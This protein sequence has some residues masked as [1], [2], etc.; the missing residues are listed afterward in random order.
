MKKKTIISIIVAIIVL[1]I[2]IE[3]ITTKGNNKEKNV[4]KDGYTLENLEEWEYEAITRT[5]KDIL[6]EDGRLLFYKRDEVD[7]LRAFK[8]YLEQK[9]PNMKFKIESIGIEGYI[10]DSEYI[11]HFYV[12]GYNDRLFTGRRWMKVGEEF[13]D[14]FTTQNEDD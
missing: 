5:S 7:E 6:T 14:N 13:R 10:G 4:E 1:L 2:I 9:Y 11:I 12:E 3:G 8:K